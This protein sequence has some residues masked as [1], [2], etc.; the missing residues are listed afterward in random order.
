MEEPSRDM[1]PISQAWISFNSIKPTMP[2]ASS[3]AAVADK[4]A[5][6]GVDLSQSENPP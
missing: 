4:L 2:F 5:F 3:C 1:R 6:E